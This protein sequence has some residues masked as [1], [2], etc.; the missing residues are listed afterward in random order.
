MK[1]ALLAVLFVTV[2]SSW[3]LAQTDSLPAPT[4]EPCQPATCSEPCQPA[5]CS[6]PCQTGACAVACQLPVCAEPFVPKWAV[7]LRAYSLTGLPGTLVLQRMLF[8]RIYLGMGFGYST[9]NAKTQNFIEDSSGTID[10]LSHV[11]NGWSVSVSPEIVWVLKKSP[12]WS[13]A[14]S[15]RAGYVYSK[16][17]YDDMYSNYYYYGNSTYRTWQEEQKRYDLSMNLLVERTIKIKNKEL[18][19]GL[20]TS[21]IKA[22]SYR[23]TQVETYYDENH[24]FVYKRTYEDKYPWTVSITNPLNTGASISIKY[25]F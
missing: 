5:A 3:C 10:T 1:K 25:W 17:K 12:K 2:F 22:S 14:T 9:N 19:V 21:F 4:A 24:V 20:E 11:G 16:N 8:N 23:D 13:Y 15:L 6:G 18:S 7:G